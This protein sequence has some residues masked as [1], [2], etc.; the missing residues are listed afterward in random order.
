[1]R[2]YSAA[3]TKP[4]GAR[5][6]HF[7]EGLEVNLNS[8]ADLNVA[9]SQ[10]RLQGHS[11]DLVAARRKVISRERPVRGLIERFLAE[12]SFLLVADSVPSQIVYPPR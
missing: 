7:W 5:R 11:D 8:P 12:V 3:G 4:S 6:E 2:T 1:M 10:R 9:A